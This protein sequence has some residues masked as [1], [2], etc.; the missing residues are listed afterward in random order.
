MD[1]YVRE[2]G[3]FG[4][5][6]LKSLSAE[7]LQHQAVAEVK[8]PKLAESYKDLAN[9][10]AYQLVIGND[11]LTSDI[12]FQ[13]KTLNDLCNKQGTSAVPPAPPAKKSSML[14]PMIAVAGIAAYLLFE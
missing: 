9:D 7:I 2:F 11:S 14:L 6:T 1:R 10:I 8:C 13:L 4:S 3:G 12:S 5:D